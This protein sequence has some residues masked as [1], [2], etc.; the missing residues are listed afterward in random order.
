MYGVK[1][2]GI[3]RHFKHSLNSLPILQLQVGSI[4]LGAW[5]PKVGEPNGRP[6]AMLRPS[7]SLGAALSMFVQ[8]DHSSL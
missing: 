8:G 6:L 5:M 1:F 4:P 7:A 3:C 2:S